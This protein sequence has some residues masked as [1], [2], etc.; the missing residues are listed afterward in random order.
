MK[1]W[2]IGVA[3]AAPM[4]LSPVMAWAQTPQQALSQRLDKVQAF[5]AD[6]AQ[7][8][9]SPDGTVLMKGKGSLDIQRPNLFRWNTVSPQANLLVSDG[10]TLWYYN[11]FVEQVTAMWLKNATAQTPFVLLTQNSD[12][13]WN[14]YSVTQ[15]D[16]TF[17][18]VPKDI[19]ATN[20]KFVI[21]VEP[22]GIVD[23]FSSVEQDGQ[24]S[25]FALTDFS[26]QKPKASLFTFKVPAG[27]ALD[28]QRN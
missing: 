18:L 16:N 1:K 27:A 4:M 10:K 8:V 22:N 19:T 24:K 3:I 17:T 2:W 6:F 26:T 5:S 13:N 11:P 23:G 9:I 15:D 20:G 7:T 12:A 25:N 14:H 28:D 21:T